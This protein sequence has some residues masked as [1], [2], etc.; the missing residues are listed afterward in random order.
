MNYRILVCAATLSSFAVAGLANGIE[1]VN[2]NQQGERGPDVPPMWVRPGYK[3]TLVAKDI[4]NARFL[5]FDDKGT[6]YVSQPNQKAITS[7]KAAADGRY[8]KLNDFVTDKPTAHGMQ[9]KDGWLYFTQTDSVWKARDKDADGK[10]DEVLPVIGKDQLVGGGGHWFRTVLVTTSSIYTSI[11]DAGNIDDGVPLGRETVFQF[12]LDGTGKRAFATGFRNT[13]KLLLRPGTEE[14]W[15]CDH[16]SDWYG[17]PVGDKE[18]RQPITDQNPPDE[19]NRIVDG[20]FYGHPYIVGNKLPR[21]EF[22]NRRDL[23]D[24]ADRCIIPEWNFNA[25]WAVNGWCF[26]TKNQFGAEHLGDAFCSLH[27]SWNSKQR[28]GY[29]VERVM[30]DKVT[31]HPYGS[32]CI[33]SALGQDGKVLARPVDCTEAPDG[34]V[35]FSCDDSRCIYRISKA[36]Q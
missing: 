8:A 34:S 4:R 16:G 35:L 30:F 18:G 20:G 22:Q 27:G 13:E 28:T 17:K 10:A 21:I 3:V 5:E 33:V 26:I 32:L 15:G 29:R 14:I 19:M 31:G 25:H 2:W 7:Y 36:G 12:N 9:W 1:A 6:L 11:G 23:I 24:L